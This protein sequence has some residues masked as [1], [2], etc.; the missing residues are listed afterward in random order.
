MVF[1][2]HYTLNKLYLNA[3]LICS[4]YVNNPDYGCYCLSRFLG[5]KI[6]TYISNYILPTM[7]FRRSFILHF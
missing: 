3:K 2:V 6:K 5:Y 1:A 7:R 4:L